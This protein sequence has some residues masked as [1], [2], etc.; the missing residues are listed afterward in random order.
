MHEVGILLHLRHDAVVKL[1]EKFET[2]RHIMLVMELA[3]G[4]DLL[5]FVRK[6]KKL[7]E[8]VA[9]VIFF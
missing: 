4:G 1:Y 6:R 2:G 3:A 8:E 9:K 7:E 5:N